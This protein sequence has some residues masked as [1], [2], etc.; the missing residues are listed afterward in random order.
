MVGFKK[1]VVMLDVS[2]DLRSGLQG[3]IPLS[4]PAQLKMLVLGHDSAVWECQCIS[5]VT[6]VWHCVS[7]KLSVK[8]KKCQVFLTGASQAVKMARI[9]VSCY[10]FAVDLCL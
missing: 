10:T 4:P 2:G 8:K 9:Y 3:E 6:L 1:K 5:Q 7:S